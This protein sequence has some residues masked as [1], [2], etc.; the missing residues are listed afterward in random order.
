MATTIGRAGT[1]I[2]I[3]PTVYDRIL[4]AASVILAGVAIVAIG[5]GIPDWPMVP[6][7]IW[8]HLATIL[9]ALLL[10]PFML[11]RAR[12]D[13]RHRRWGMAWLASMF[14]T[15]ILSFGIRTGG[16]LSPIYILSAVTAIQVPLI[17][18]SARQHR[19]AAHRRGIRILV[20]GG[21]L[22]AGFFTFPFG[23]LLGRWLFA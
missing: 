1:S 12:G 16:G 10:T 8:A 13:V 19:I 6:A 3:A 18:R 2:G 23:R 5:R 15:A 17:W 20:T 11:L 7:I 21:L 4:A 9:I 14:A 22:I